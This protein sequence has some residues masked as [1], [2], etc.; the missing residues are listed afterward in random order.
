MS[1]VHPL[2][3]T[4]VRNADTRAAPSRTLS[5][6]VTL[7]PP[8]VTSFT[9]LARRCV[10]VATSPD[11]D[12]A[13]KADSS[14]ACFGVHGAGPGPCRYGARGPRFAHARSRAARQ[15]AASRLAPA[16]RLGHLRERVVE[17][18]VQQKRSALERREPVQRQQQRDGQIF[19]HLG[20]RIGCKPR[21][22][23]DRIGQPRPD[24]LLPAH[25]R[26]LQH[27]QTDPRRR[28]D[29]KR[30]RLHDA[31]AIGVVPAQVGL[32][33]GV[34]GFCHRSEHAIRQPEQ[35]P[36]VRLEAR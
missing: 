17:H 30:P 28:R 36:P 9:S 3:T 27:V 26:R 13:M 24:I 8:S 18:V 5:A 35:A 25:S 7:P 21:R 1:S 16:Q 14:S 29:Q 22:V 2:R 31:L 11:R 32:L 34:L 12:A 19:R 23:G 6:A 15:L 4:P 10:S 33:H 20:L